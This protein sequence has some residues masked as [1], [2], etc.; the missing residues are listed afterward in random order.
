MRVILV[1]NQNGGKSTVFNLLTHSH[2]RVGNYP[3]ITVDCGV[4]V[5]DGGVEVVDLPGVYSLSPYTDE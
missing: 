4:G 2:R 1:G 5:T 3:G